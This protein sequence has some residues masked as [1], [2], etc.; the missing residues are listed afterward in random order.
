MM[1][2]L[3]YWVWLSSIPALGAVRGRKLLEFFVTPEGIWRANRSSLLKVQDMGPVLVE[4]LMDPVLRLEAEKHL[5]NMDKANVSAITLDNPE[6]PALLKEIYDPPLVIYKKGKFVTNKC[7][8]VIGSRR[9][10]EY[11]LG[12]AEKL[13]YDLAGYGINVVSG[14]ARGIDSRAHEGALRA[15]GTT[16]AVLGCGVDVIYPPENEYLYRKIIDSGAL[17]SEYLPGYPPLP[18]NF[19]ARNRIISGLCSGVV[20]I[21]AN[22]KS[23]SLITANFALEQGRDVFSVPGNIGNTNSKG[24]NRLIREG[25]KIVTGV[26]DILD[27]INF[28]ESNKRQNP[29]DKVMRPLEKFIISTDNL[30]DDEKKIINALYSGELHID[31]LSQKTGIDAKTLNSL[32]IILEL[33]GFVEQKAGKMFSIKNL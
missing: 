27:E 5:K 33:N 29:A 8:A 10:S 23:G 28:F 13:A 2:S 15:S 30:R 14:L 11:G 12:V 20:V 16:T 26:K 22:E 21:E 24:T 19:P 31:T 6:Y 9:A 3:V 17:I 18:G 25:A 32:L 4:R 7:I 1:D